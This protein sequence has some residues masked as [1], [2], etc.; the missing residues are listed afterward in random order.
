MY[1]NINVCID[2]GS[3]RIHEEPSPGTVLGVLYVCEACGHKDQLPGKRVSQEPSGPAPS[4]GQ[5]GPSGAGEQ[6]SQKEVQQ[7]ETGGCSLTVKGITAIVLVWFCWSVGTRGIIT[8]FFYNPGA[9]PDDTV[10]WVILGVS[11]LFFFWI[12]A[13]WVWRKARGETVIQRSKGCVWRVAIWL[14]VLLVAAGFVLT[15]LSFL[16]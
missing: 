7:V 11:T 6:V 5:Q 12:V 15:V 1:E 16:S 13:P 10:S 9:Y 3:P 14:V 8:L 4:G 2:C